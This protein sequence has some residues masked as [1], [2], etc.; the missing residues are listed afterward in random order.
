MVNAGITKKKDFT[1]AWSYMEKNR[2]TLR[3]ANQSD[4]AAIAKSLDKIMMDEP[5]C[6]VLPIKPGMWEYMI[7]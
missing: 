4:G 7:N 5:I 1:K 3:V 6:L 2:L